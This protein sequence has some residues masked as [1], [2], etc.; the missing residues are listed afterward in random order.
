M[1]RSSAMA[2]RH[3]QA[4]GRGHWPLIQKGTYIYMPIGTALEL[5]GSPRGASLSPPFLLAWCTRG[6][7]LG[8]DKTFVP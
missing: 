6:S 8:D 4:L 5:L 2:E 1:Q 3:R 7:F